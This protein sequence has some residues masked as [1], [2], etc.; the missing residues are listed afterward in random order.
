[1][2]IFPAGRLFSGFCENVWQKKKI[3]L[4]YGCEIR[5]LVKFG[6]RKL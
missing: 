6:R 2:E 1:M 3:M 5:N 4:Q